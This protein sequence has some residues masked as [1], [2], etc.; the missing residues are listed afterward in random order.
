[1]IQVTLV[2]PFRG[3]GDDVRIDAWVR[4]LPR[5]GDRVIGATAWVTVDYIQWTADPAPT[6]LPMVEVVAIPIETDPQL[7]LADHRR[8]L[9]DDFGADPD[10]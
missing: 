8:S 6:E 4:D 5:R 7:T 2:I 1:M 9:L 3:G 10:A